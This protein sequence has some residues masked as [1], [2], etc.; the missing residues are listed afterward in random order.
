MTTIHKPRI[1]H[2]QWQ[3]LPFSRGLTTPVSYREYNTSSLYGEL[4]IPLPESSSQVTLTSQAHL[5]KTARTMDTTASNQVLSFSST[6]VMSSYFPVLYFL[7]S[8]VS[9][10]VNTPV[11]AFRLYIRS[12]PCVQLPVPGPVHTARLGR[13]CF[14]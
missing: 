2:L 12:S 8:L 7:S 14:I 3:K 5:I 4:R 11:L 9:P 10:S 13:V 6:A 1:E